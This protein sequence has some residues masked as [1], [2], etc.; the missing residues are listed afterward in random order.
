MKK[1]VDSNGIAMLIDLD[2][3]I[4]CFGCEAACRETNR[5]SY[6][7]DWL[8]LIRREPWLV[9]GKLRQYHLPAP[10]LDKCASCYF[11]QEKNPLCMSGCPTLALKVGPFEE[12]VK[13]A[14][15]RH[16]MIYSA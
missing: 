1:R 5:Y 3:C 12:V 13:E 11:E 6:D 2:D 8:K 14:A 7:E 15:G 16:C 4:G 9:D 10:G